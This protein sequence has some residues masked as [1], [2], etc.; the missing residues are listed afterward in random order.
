[1]RR[2]L[3]T[4]VSSVTLA[5]GAQSVVAQEVVTPS[6][7]EAPVPVPKVQVAASAPESVTPDQLLQQDG[8][9]ADGYAAKRLSGLGPW[10]AR[11]QLDTPYNASV[12]PDELI[13][14]LQVN[15][16]T[17]L[18][19]VAPFLQPYVAESNGT[20]SGFTIRGFG[21]GSIGGGSGVLSLQDGFITPSSLIQDLEDKERI[22]VVTGATGFL[23]GE[24]S[25]GGS[26]NYVQ[27]RPTAAPYASVTAGDY[28]NSVGYIHGDFGGPLGTDGRVGYRVNLLAQDGDT[29][30]SGESRRRFLA[31]T[32][33]DFRAADNALL[34][35]NVA[36]RDSYM[37][38]LQS[39]WGIYTTNSVPAAPDPTKAWGEPWTYSRDRTFQS[40]GKFTWAITDYLTSRTGLL[41]IY[42]KLDWQNVENDIYDGGSYDQIVYTSNGIEKPV[43]SEYQYFDLKFATASI[44]HKV[45][46]GANGFQQS[47]RVPYSWW[48]ENDPYLSSLGSIYT[49]P[50]HLP[51]QDIFVDSDNSEKL[52]QKNSNRNFLIGDDIRFDAQWSMLLGGTYARIVQS[53]YVPTTGHEQSSYDKSKL[54]PAVSLIFKPLPWLSTYASYLEG[55]DQGATAPNNTTNAG[56]VTPPTSSRSYEVGAKAE[57]GRT[58]LTVSL[59]DTDRAFT[60]TRLNG[61]G[62]RTFVQDGRE[63][64]KGVEVGLSGKVLDNL[65]LY[66]GVTHMNPKVTDSQTLDGARPWEVSDTMG[67]LYAEYSVP[68]IRGLTLTGGVDYVSKMQIYSFPYPANNLFV[69]GYT[70]GDLGARFATVFHGTPAVFRL[71]VNNI[72]DEHYWLTDGY[73]G[74]PRTVA[75]SGQ[76]KF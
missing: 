13:E 60:Y 53:T 68:R 29:Y 33:F 3:A 38:G 64:H 72:S 16:M 8:T 40:S 70:T 14:N 31:S 11:S 63:V 71:D 15:N 73:L 12:I 47:W 36:Y 61:D 37:K 34:Q 51:P 67:K 21:T 25:P 7:A 65:T 1:M 52:R 4:G 74:A 5:L 22:E 18:A 66:G 58:L 10:T 50:V 19:K 32:A 20:G 23:Y 39:S 69:R 46:L 17:E 9:A 49:G 41:Y 26:I 75:F 43:V 27:K 59:F 24:N 6:A 44:R 76:V 62:T 56:I 2:W 30:V 45:T 55:L 28:G 35:V 42:D 57:I 54:A 48:T